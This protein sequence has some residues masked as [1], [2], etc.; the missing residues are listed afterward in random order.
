MSGRIHFHF[1][2]TSVFFDCQMAS[3]IVTKKPCEGTATRKSRQCLPS[4]HTPRP[5]VQITTMRDGTKKDVSDRGHEDEERRS[6]PAQLRRRSS[7]KES[8]Q[9]TGKLGVDGSE[10]KS[11]A[12]TE[13]QR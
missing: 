6:L 12:C 3:S 10:R 13:S 11:R 5:V 8:A 4:D 1:A 9:S 7:F 2:C